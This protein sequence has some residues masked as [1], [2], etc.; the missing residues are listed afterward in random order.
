MASSRLRKA[1][2]YPSEDDDDSNEDLDE[3][4]QE[5]LIADFK[6][7]DG[8]KNEQYRLAFLAVPLVA[9][10]F[11]ALRVAL[12]AS[13]RQRLSGFLGLS[14]LLCTAYV[15]HFMPLHAPE[16]KG[17]RPVYQIEAEKTPIERYLVWLNAALALVML[18]SASLSWK[19]NAVDDAWREALPACM[20]IYNIYTS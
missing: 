1:F 16:R 11:F 10:M 18:L 2:K 5:R 20:S 9:A 14:S 19:A 6:A 3:E 13:K 8:Q 7:Q 4:H 12:A 17:K 15:L